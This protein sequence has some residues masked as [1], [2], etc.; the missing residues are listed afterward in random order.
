M[1]YRNCAIRE[2]FIFKALHPLHS[3]TK[4]LGLAITF[5]WQSILNYQG[6]CPKFCVLTL[7]ILKD[8]KTT[9]ARMFGVV[10]KFLQQVK[11]LV[12]ATTLTGLEWVC[13]TD[14]ES[15]RLVLVGDGL[16]SE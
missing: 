12:A 9:T 15:T 16:L 10:V 7:P 14:A 2:I 4:I 6:L 1:E 5:Q 3:Q 11:L 13:T 8:N